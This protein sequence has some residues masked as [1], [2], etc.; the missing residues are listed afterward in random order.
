MTMSL[1]VLGSP[2]FHSIVRCGDAVEG[3]LVVVRPAVEVVAARGV[4]VSFV[5]VVRPKAVV[6]RGGAVSFLV[7]VGWQA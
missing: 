6:E 2:T 1:S 4:V 3:A 7:V 5:A